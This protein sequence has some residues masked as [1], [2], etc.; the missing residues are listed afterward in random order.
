MDAVAYGSPPML[1]AGCAI[2]IPRYPRLRRELLGSRSR[3]VTWL[4]K[5]A[6]AP[7]SEDFRVFKQDGSLDSYHVPL[8]LSLWL[9][10]IGG[11]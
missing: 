4:K 10:T 3:Q 7:S 8:L 9:L 11:N 1:Q 2:S 6:S 5:Q